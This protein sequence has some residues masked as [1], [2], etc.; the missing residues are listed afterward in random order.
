M[1]NLE[2]HLI[3]KRCPHCRVDNPNITELGKYQTTNFDGH[4]L[5][6]WAIYK[7][8]RCGGLLMASSDLPKGY[9]RELYPSVIK[10]EDCLPE[11]AKAFLDQA[12]DS[13]HAPSGAIMLAASSI[14]AML[15]DKGYTKGSLSARINQ[16]KNDHLIT[17]GM[18][19]WAHEVRLGAN[20]E[21]HADEDAQLPDE[22][23]A[24]KTVDFALAL[25]E[26]LFVLPSRVEKGIESATKED[27][28]KE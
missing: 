16:A 23:D 26:F 18:S 20:D 9:V 4:N 8:N 15:K 21:R 2:N 14:D 11:K 6:Y 27:K 10:V 28:P 1:A 3:L 25:A 7:C 22:N 17:D 13:L 19:K 24:K 12:I 5:R